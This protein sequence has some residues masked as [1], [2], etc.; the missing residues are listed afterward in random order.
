MAPERVFELC[1]STCILFN[2]YIVGAPCL[3]VPHRGYGTLRYRGLA[4]A[5]RDF[6]VCGGCW[7]QHPPLPADTPRGDWSWF[8][9]AELTQP[10]ILPTGMPRARERVPTADMQDHPSG[11]TW[12]LFTL[13]PVILNFQAEETDRLSPGCN[14][15]LHLQLG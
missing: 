6:A 15:C 11:I 4:M 1:E 13:L 12:T 9:V 7:N 2:E 14:N 10:P 8:P 5:L 3:Q